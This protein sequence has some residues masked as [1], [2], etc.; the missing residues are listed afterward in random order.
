MPWNPADMTPQQRANW[1]LIESVLS[2]EYE[3]GF[4]RGLE[5]G[6][7]QARTEAPDV[8]EVTKSALEMLTH[9]YEAEKAPE[10]KKILDIPAPVL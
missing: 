3:R 9:D 6:Q 2:S 7:E 8:P 4:K 1:V 10:G 5:V